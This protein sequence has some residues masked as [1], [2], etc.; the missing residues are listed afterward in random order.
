MKHILIFAHRG[1]SGYAPDN[2]RESFELALKMGTNFLESDVKLTRDRQLVFFHDTFVGH[3][4]VSLVSLKHLQS[5]DMGKGTRVSKVDELFGHFQGKSITWSIDARG[6]GQATELVHLAK[7]YQILD[8]VYIANEGYRIKKK[9]EQIGMPGDQYIWS[10][11]DKQVRRFGP[12]KVIKLCKEQGI[13]ILNIKLGWMTTPLQQA[14]VA[15]GIKLFIWDCHDGESI[16]TALSFQPDAI[17]SNYPDV[18][19]KLAQS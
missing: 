6:K 9:W 11:R 12:E 3:C 19:L 10:I 17:Y 1:A 4:P 13:R 8:H 5:I 15:E 2:T 16:K 14:I 7:K 18:A